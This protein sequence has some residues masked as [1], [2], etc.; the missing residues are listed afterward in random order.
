LVAG[1]V[2]EPVARSTTPNRLDPVDRVLGEELARCRVGSPYA[3]HVGA[4]R[5]L[6]HDAGPVHRNRPPTIAPT[7]SVAITR[8]TVPFG[9]SSRITSPG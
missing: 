2:V 5:L 1:R 6:D 8:P 3:T 9:R 4:E 7:E